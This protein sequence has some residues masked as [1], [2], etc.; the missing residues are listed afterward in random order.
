MD[1]S[2]IMAK[3]GWLRVESHSLR[4]FFN[5]LKWVKPGQEHLVLNGQFCYGQIRRFELIGNLF[6]RRPGRQIFN[7]QR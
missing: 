3:L 5:G 7:D 1:F 2:T 4:Q 6:V